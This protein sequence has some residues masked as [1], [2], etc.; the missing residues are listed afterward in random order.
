MCM[1]MYMMCVSLLTVSKK[2]ACD[3]LTC[4]EEMQVIIMFLVSVIS[5]FL[6]LFPLLPIVQVH[7]NSCME[8]SAK[9]S[10]ECKVEVL[11]GTKH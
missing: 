1:R 3:L 9:N 8:H 10:K 4:G 6:C 2:L 5:D 7:R 11:E